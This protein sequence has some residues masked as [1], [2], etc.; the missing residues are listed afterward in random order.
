MDKFQPGDLVEIGHRRGWIVRKSSDAWDG[1][2]AWWVRGRFN[3]DQYRLPE[4]VLK[5]VD[6]I[7]RLGGLVDD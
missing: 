2:T 4:H 7:E 5:H 3:T 6:V 1:E